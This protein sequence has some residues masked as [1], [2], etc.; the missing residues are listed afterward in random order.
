M[1]NFSVSFRSSSFYD[2][3]M[4]SSYS[5]SVIPSSLDVQVGDTV[6][7]SYVRQAGGATSVSVSGFD[8]GEWN[9]TAISVLTNGQSTVRTVTAAGTDTIL[10]NYSGASGF[11]T[12]SV[13]ITAT[14]SNAPPNASISGDTTGI[15][16]N[17]V[18]VDAGSSVDPD[19]DTISYSFVVTKNAVAQFSRGSSTDPTWSWTPITS[20][21]YVTEVTASDGV[22]T[23]V[24]TLTSVISASSSSSGS[25]GGYGFEVFDS[26]GNLVLNNKMMFIRKG[27]TLTTNSSGY[28]TKTVTGVSTTAKVNIPIAGADTAS[29]T[30]TG[31]GTTSRVITVTN[32]AL[33][34][35]YPIA[36]MR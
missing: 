19:G 33:S 5:T 3:E 4:G 2:D 26:L 24:A 32:G 18:N 28:G 12:R 6:T 25:D 9:S 20:G 21:T 15:V 36:I 29:V 23:D 34:T 31:A 17:I 14:S 13:A 22:A 7:F 35:V 11:L 8:T 10:G 27:P 16:G 1:A 30:V